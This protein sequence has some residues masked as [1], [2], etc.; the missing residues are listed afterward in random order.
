MAEPLTVPRVLWVAL[1]A[2][3]LIYIA[4]LEVVAIEP[5]SGW[6]SLLPAFALG[7]LMAAG[8][9]LIAPRFVPQKPRGA[10]SAQQNSYV[11]ALILSLAL[12]ESVCILGL[13]LGFLGAPAAVVLPFFV[14]TWLLMFLRFPT[15]Q[16]LEAFNG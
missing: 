4:V 5:Q 1:F 11:V 10:P 13:V 6:Q 9:S 7:G 2:S 16:K 8:G 15:Q 3:T 14:V 12:A